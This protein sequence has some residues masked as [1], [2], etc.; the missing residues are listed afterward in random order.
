MPETKTLAHYQNLKYP[1]EMIE[2][3]DAYVVSIPDLPGCIA[4][5]DTLPEALE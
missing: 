4:Y 2:D 5:G 3:D 1:M